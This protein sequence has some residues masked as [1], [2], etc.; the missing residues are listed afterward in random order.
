[1]KKSKTYICAGAGLLVL[2]S[3]ILFFITKPL[4][5]NDEYEVTNIICDRIVYGSLSEIDNASAIIAE[6]TAGE[7]V[8]QEVS[9]FYDYA[10]K[11]E[12]P[13]GGYTKREVEVNKVYKG[14]IEAGDKLLLLHDYYK[15]TYEDG[16]KQLISSSGFMPMNEGE[17]YL[18]FLQKERNKDGYSVTGDYLGIYPISTISKYVRDSK[19]A[20]FPYIYETY[21]SQDT[22]KL[23]TM[24]DNVTDKYYR[25]AG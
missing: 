25:E 3:V 20:D 10:F 2:L 21:I 4:S 17:K 9:S 19:S 18:V 12:I 16:T 6:V 11:K 13:N 1:M 8:G 7:E 24:Y 23:L 5:V 15:W 22:D 14:N